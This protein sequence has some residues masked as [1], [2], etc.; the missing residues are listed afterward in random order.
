M[1]HPIKL[2]FVIPVYNEAENIGPLH[3]EIKAVCEANNYDY[4]IIC[5]DDC[6]NDNTV[7]VLKSLSPVKFIQFRKQFG[8]T[9]AMDAGIKEAKYTYIVTMDGDGQNDPADV[10]KLLDHLHENDLDVVSGWR[11]ERKDTF[12]KRFVS[13]GAN[14]LRSLMIKDGINDSGCSL[15]VYKKECFDYVT[16]YGEMHRFIPA[17]LKIQG[18][19]VGEVVVNHRARTKGL[20]KYTWSRSIKG[21]IDMISVW[22]SQKYAFRPLH[23]LGGLGIFLFLLSFVFAGITVFEYLNGQDLSDTLWLTVT[24]LTFVMGL[25]VFISGLLM[26]IMIKSYHETTGKKHY[27]IKQIVENP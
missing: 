21:F 9:S 25:L 24:L 17:L 18:F 1:N 7:E 6:S 5:V 3:A 4:E 20:S 26:D 27:H 23:L 16:L 2:S 10:P 12:S 15:K 13:R 8:Q 11:K 22:F 19:K 14:F